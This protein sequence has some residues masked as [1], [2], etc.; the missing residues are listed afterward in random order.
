MKKRRTIVFL[1]NDIDVS[2]SNLVYLMTKKAA[3]KY[4]CNLIVYEGRSFNNP[5]MADSQHQISYSFVDNTRLD[6]IIITSATIACFIS[7][8][9]FVEFCKRYEGIPLVSLGIVVPHATSILVDNKPGMK[10]QVEHLIKDHG[11]KK[12][13]YI[14]GPPTNTDSVERLE[15]YCEALRK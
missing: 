12:I 6:G 10:S 4:D 8:E 5:S 1:V 15:A 13:V 14:S 7:D 9:E 11:F 2:Y 3:E